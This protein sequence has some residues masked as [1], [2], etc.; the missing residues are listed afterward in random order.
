METLKIWSKVFIWG[1]KTHFSWTHTLLTFFL[2]PVPLYKKG[3]SLHSEL[4]ISVMMNDTS[5]RV[6]SYTIQ[7]ACPHIHQLL[8][9][10]FRSACVTVTQPDPCGAAQ[11][12]TGWGAVR[13]SCLTW[14]CAA[15]FR[16]GCLASWKQHEQQQAPFR[17][18]RVCNKE[19]PFN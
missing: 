2:T 8:T 13:A 7:S 19:G 4:S 10:S 6:L 11:L 12:T 18:T 17:L 5:Y 15:S 14:K 3:K 1:K 16:S 9:T